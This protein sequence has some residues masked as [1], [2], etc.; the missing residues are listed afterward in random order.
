M[1][2]AAPQGVVSPFV[3]TPPDVKLNGGCQEPTEPVWYE[4]HTAKHR[5][6]HLDDQG[7]RQR[8][9]RPKRDHLS[10]VLTLFAQFFLLYGSLGC[11][12]RT[13]TG[14]FNGVDEIRS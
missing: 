4:G 2:A 3:E 7:G 8:N 10:F 9:G 13:I 5:V 1:F 12:L 6:E 11:Q 14:F